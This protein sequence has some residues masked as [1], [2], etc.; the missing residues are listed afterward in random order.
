MEKKFERKN[1]T[2]ALFTNEKVLSEKHPN[3]SGTI[4]TPDGKEYRIAA[5][6]KQGNKGRYL[7]LAIS[8]K[9]EQSENNFS[10]NNSN[11]NNSEDTLN[12]LPF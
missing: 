5:W 11:Q 1:G 12:D 8:E 2:G 3:M 9:K 6:T 4:V 7:S 10:S